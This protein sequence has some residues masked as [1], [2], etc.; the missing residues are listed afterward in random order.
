MDEATW[1][2][3]LELKERYLMQ[4]YGFEEGKDYRADYVNITMDDEPFQVRYLVLG[5]NAS[6]KPTLVLMHC[7][8]NSSVSAYVQWFQH[9][10]PTYRIVCFD[11]CGWGLNTRRATC[12]GTESAD[13]AES[14]LL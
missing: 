14:W 12:S 7:Y 8:M 3:E 9:L 1:R 2:G 4:T 6:P 13:A 10:L 5:E 11:N